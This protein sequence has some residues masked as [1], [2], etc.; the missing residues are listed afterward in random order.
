LG[1]AAIAMGNAF[2][3]DAKRLAQDFWHSICGGTKDLE[4]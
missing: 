4:F 2:A 3:G 1:L